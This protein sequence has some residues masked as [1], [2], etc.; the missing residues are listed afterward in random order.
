[1]A[2]LYRRISPRIIL[3]ILL[4]FA[5]S[6]ILTSTAWMWHQTPKRQAPIA[7]PHNYKPLRVQSHPIDHLM[8]NATE[9]FQILLSKESKNLTEASDA[10]RKRRGRDPPPGFAEW[11]AFAQDRDAVI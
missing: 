6:F 1:M 11:F 10:Y 4:F 5:V 3:R 2:S 7:M 9:S 8:T